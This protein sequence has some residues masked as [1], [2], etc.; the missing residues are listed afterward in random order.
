[1]ASLRA[2]IDAELDAARTEFSGEIRRLKSELLEARKESEIR[3][4][5]LREV[6]K[7]FE[8]L[9]ESV[10]KKTLRTYNQAEFDDATSRLRS[11]AFTQVQPSM[12]DSIVPVSG[13]WDHCVSFVESIPF[14]RIANGGSLT[15]SDHV[16][17]KV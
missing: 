14:A 4:A 13:N 12:S 15:E 8:A 7:C 5:A 3:G 2:H 6:T 1:M 11:M 16:F 10:P 17:E 9:R